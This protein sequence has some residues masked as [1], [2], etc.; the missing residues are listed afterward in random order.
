MDIGL[1]VFS[2]IN[3]RSVTMYNMWNTEDIIGRLPSGLPNLQKLV[4]TCWRALSDQRLI[5][6]LNRSRSNLRELDLS[7]SYIT[8]VGVEDGVNSLPNLGTMKL[9][10]CFN[11]TDVG[12]Q[13]MLR[14]S[15]CTLRELDASFTNI[16]GKGVKEGVSLPMLEE[17][18]LGGCDQLTDSGLLEILSISDIRL[19][20]VNV[21]L[22]RNISTAIRSTLIT[23]YPSVEFIYR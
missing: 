2:N 23:Q 3:L 21:S 22:C 8:G 16:T 9:S 10:Q 4:L 17:L 1:T 5:E 15:R 12:L 14:L 13:K 19:K 18:N 11:L 20:T 6:I 7:Y